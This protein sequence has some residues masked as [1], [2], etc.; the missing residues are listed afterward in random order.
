M[1]FLQIPTTRSDYF[2]DHL[3]FDAE[4][5]AIV[6]STH[7]HLNTKYQKCT[8]P[9]EYDPV[10]DEHIQEISAALSNEFGAELII[11]NIE[12]GIIECETCSVGSSQFLYNQ[13]NMQTDRIINALQLEHKWT[14]PYTPPKTTVSTSNTTGESVVP[15]VD[16]NEIDI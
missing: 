8:I 1:Q 16:P 4:W 2:D 12:P 15:A 13:G 6:R 3:H 7:Q 5:L 9:V 11:P 10:L 14:K